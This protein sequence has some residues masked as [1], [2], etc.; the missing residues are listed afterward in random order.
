MHTCA[1]HLHKL[2]IDWRELATGM[3]ELLMHP[4]YFIIDF[5]ARQ[6][7]LHSPTSHPHSRE[8]PTHKPDVDSHK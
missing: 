5:H 8:R 2:P 1:T 3:H 7:E 6:T 4:H